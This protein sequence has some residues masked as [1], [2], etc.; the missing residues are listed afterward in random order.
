MSSISSPSGWGLAH[1]WLGKIH[2]HIFNDYSWGL[3]I[4]AEW[5]SLVQTQHCH[6]VSVIRW[7]DCPPALSLAL[8]LWPRTLLSTQLSLGCSVWLCILLSSSSFPAYALSLM[9]ASHCGRLARAAVLYGLSF[10]LFSI[11]TL[12][13]IKP[14][15]PC[16][17]AS[18]VLP[19]L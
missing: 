1:P 15:S 5:G 7:D 11:S 9:G 19:H 18:D 12:A 6:A 4:V 10:I 13:A 17:C 8:S 14:P 16:L 2:S 3:E